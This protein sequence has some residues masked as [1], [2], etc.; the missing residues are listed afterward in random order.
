MDLTTRYMGLTL[1]NPLVASASPLSERVD[2]IRQLEDSGASAVVLFSLFE[3][4]IRHDSAALDYFITRDTESFGEALSYFPAIDDYDVGPRQYLELIRKATDA[5]DI[6][7][8]ASL[9]GVTERGWVNFAKEMAD[10]GAGGIELNVYYIPTE[11]TRTGVEVEQQYV[12]VLT[13]VK[14][15]VS[16]PVAIKV[17]PYFSSFANMAHRFDDAGA[18]AM[19]LF[20]R[21]YQPDFDIETRTVVP[22]IALS[23]PAEIR[24]PLLWLSLLHGRVRASLAATTGVHSAVEAIKYLMAGADVVMSTSAVLRQG[25]TFFT[26]T[27]ADMSAWL[28]KKGYS[29]VAQLRG[30]MSQRSAPDSAAFV[31]GNYIKVLESYTSG[32]PSS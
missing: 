29:S 3:E 18:D 15:A 10:A 13:A 20:N 23:T 1:K 17:G 25:P 24:L 4:Q 12:D 8:I 5:V 9:N 7:V 27:L 28:E 16:I 11:A 14:R 26:R 30:C 6:P 31:R 22:S 19:V 32:A 21:F 2:V